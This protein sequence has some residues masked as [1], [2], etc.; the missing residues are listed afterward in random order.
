MFGWAVSTTGRAVAVEFYLHGTLLTSAALNIER[1]DVVTALDQPGTPLLCGFHLRISKLT[2]PRGA[3][4]DLQLWEELESGEPGRV[5]LGTVTG[6]PAPAMTMRYAERFNPLLLLGMGRSGT[7]YMMQLLAAHPEI[8]VPGPYPYEMRQPVWLWHAASVMSAPG[9][10][11][12]MQPDGLEAERVEW[13]GYNPYRSRDWEKVAGADAAMAWQEEE[14]PLACIDF[15]KEQ[16]D[17]FSDRCVEGRPTVPRFVAQKMLITPTRY[18]VSNIYAQAR[19][20][21]LVRDFRDVWLSARSFNLK[22][23]R[24]SFQ[25]NQFPNDRAWMEGLAFSSRQ[26]RLA[27][28]AAGGQAQV[29]RYEDL[30]RDPHTTLSRL[31]DFLGIDGSSLRVGAVTAAAS[32]K[33]ADATVEHRTSVKTGTVPRWEAEMTPDEKAIAERV[34]G[35]DLAYFGYAV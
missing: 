11:T 26:M 24:E 23:G 18:F 28:G 9:S 2:L 13:L 35:E 15:C 34:F 22:R 10:M 32:N 31:F 17:D 7:T 3:K 21:I 16:V 8:L 12:S 14:L 20:I 5:A 6:L 19:E 25:R 4:L 33:D 1:P 30:I 29:V 27:H